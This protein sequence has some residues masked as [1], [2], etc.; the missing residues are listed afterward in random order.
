MGKGKK[1][2]MYSL[3]GRLNTVTEV[4]SFCTYNNLVRLALLGP[5]FLFLKG[6]MYICMYVCMYVCIYLLE[7][8]EGREKE[9]ERNINVGEKCQSVAF[10][11]HAP[12]WAPGLQPRPVP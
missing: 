10:H 12:N 9:R 3:G 1:E 8:K 6:C 2:Y 5:Y 7:I 4:I 11:M